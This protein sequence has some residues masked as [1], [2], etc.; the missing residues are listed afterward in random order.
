MLM[1]TEWPCFIDFNPDDDEVWINT[2]LEQKRATMIGDVDVIISTFRDN[3]F[4]SRSI[5]DEILNLR[6]TDP[7]MWKVY[8]NAEY[9]KI[10]GAIFEE[11]VHWEVIEEIP[12]EA[13]FKWYGQ[14]Y[15]FTTDPTTLIWIHTYWNNAIVLDEVFWENNLV[16]TYQDESQSQQSIQ[17]QYEINWVDKSSKIYADSSEPKS[18]E[19][20]FEV[21]YNIE[22]VK[23][24]PWSVVSWIKFMKKY[25]I[26]VTARSL[27]LRN[28]F[29][30]YVWATDKMWKVL[31]DKEWRPIPLDKY[32][33]GIDSSRYWITH[34]LSWPDMS[35]L[36]LSIL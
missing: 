4:L 20:L 3:A 10:K 13:Q 9:W 35:S 11:G 18:N 34:L 31:R 25:K 26:Y 24:W 32:N 16:N 21:W 28:E 14:D 12:E 8:G 27:N 19:E 36:D 23:K 22:G 2:E 33:H 17:G 1:R 29:K 7:E 5:V 6:H 30:K 15:W